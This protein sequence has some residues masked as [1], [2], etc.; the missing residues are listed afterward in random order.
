MDCGCCHLTMLHRV[1]L[2]VWIYYMSVCVCVCVSVCPSIH[3]VLF[4]DTE[5]RTLRL[6][7]EDS[8]GRHHVLTVELK[9]KVTHTH[10]KI[11]TQ[12]CTICTHTY[13]HAPLSAHQGWIILNEIKYIYSQLHI[14]LQSAK[15]QTFKSHPA[16]RDVHFT[17]KKARVYIYPPHPKSRSDTE[18]VW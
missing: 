6:K 12:A 9:I 16:H 17:D 8:S 2:R 1:H 10:T 4:I 11:Q 14:D 13:T 5:F 18:R 15:F 3:R 7:A